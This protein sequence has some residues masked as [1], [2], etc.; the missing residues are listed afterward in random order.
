M[1]T[2]TLRYNHC[3]WLTITG[4]EKHWERAEVEAEVINKKSFKITTKNVAGLWIQMGSGS[5]AAAQA[6]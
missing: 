2:Y 6:S 4:L 3:F 5:N 1:V